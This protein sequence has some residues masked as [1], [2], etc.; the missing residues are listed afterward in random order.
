[1]TKA[2]VKAKPSQQQQEQLFCVNEIDWAKNESVLDV[3]NVVLKPYNICKGN[4]LK[5]LRIINNNINNN[6]DNN[7]DGRRKNL[8]SRRRS[9]PTN[10]Q[11]RL[12]T[13][14]SFSWL[15]KVTSFYLMHN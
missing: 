9:A 3:K 6:N 11:I 13:L 5:S 14:K 15:Q 8:S 12:K 7:N 10:E 2:K 1:M 4:V